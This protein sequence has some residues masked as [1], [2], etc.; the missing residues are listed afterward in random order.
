M[1]MTDTLNLASLW[2]QIFLP[3]LQVDQDDT[4]GDKITRSSRLTQD[5]T[6]DQDTACLCA[7]EKKFTLKEN[8]QYG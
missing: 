7:E 1:I 6:R 8:I 4:R 3:L 2:N 5:Q